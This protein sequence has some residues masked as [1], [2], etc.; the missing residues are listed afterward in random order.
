MQ[1]R[2]LAHH[3]VI[4]LTRVLESRD[5]SGAELARRMGVSQDYVWRRMS[6]RVEPSLSDLERMAAALDESVDDLLTARSAA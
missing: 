1:R 3:V 4:T 6:G 2:S 5:I